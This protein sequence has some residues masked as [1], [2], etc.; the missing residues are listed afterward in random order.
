MTNLFAAARTVFVVVL[1][2]FAGLA[3]GALA[4]AQTT[5][6]PPAPAPLG[7]PATTG[8]PGLPGTTPTT[9]TGPTFAQVTTSIITFVDQYVAPL[10]YALAFLFF[11]FGMFRFFFT[12]G[13]ESRS[14][15]RQFAVWSLIALGVMFSVWGLV[16]VLLS[17]IPGTSV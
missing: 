8:A 4:H 2:C 12:G 14:Q 5:G 9:P 13:E 6:V 11:I 1:F 17:T 10:L 15:G 3:A 16:H 7:T